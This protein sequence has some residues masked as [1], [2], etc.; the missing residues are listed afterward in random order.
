MFDLHLV[1][2]SLANSSQTKSAYIDN[3]SQIKYT[4]IQLHSR[5]YHLTIHFIK[6][7]VMMCEIRL[8]I[9]YMQLFY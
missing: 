9:P 8:E 6:F 4:T 2:F 3:H 5:D 7:V 1:G